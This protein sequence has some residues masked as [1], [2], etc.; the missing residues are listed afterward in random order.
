MSSSAH[1]TILII[2]DHKDS[3]EMVG[4]IL[5][6]NGYAAGYAGDGAEALQAL[7]AG[8]R[9]ALILLDWRMPGMDGATFL[10][11]LERNE[12]YASIPVVLVSANAALETKRSATHVLVKPINPD[13]LVELVRSLCG[14]PRV[15]GS[16]DGVPR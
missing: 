4:T 14:L 3:R 8:L 10:A 15:A 6:L 16:L 2:D 13:S 9:P 1:E 12:A 11:E 7:A 5:E